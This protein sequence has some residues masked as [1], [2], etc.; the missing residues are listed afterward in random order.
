MDSSLG[1][2]ASDLAGDR[3]RGAA[4]LLA[5]EREPVRLSGTHAFLTGVNRLTAARWLAATG[6]TAT[7]TR[8]LTWHEAVGDKRP[9]TVHA[10][11]IL[12]PFAYLA[13]ARLLAG[14]GQ[15]AA[16][17]ENYI[18]FLANYDAPVQAHQGL[19]DEANAAVTRLGPR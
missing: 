2:F 5:L 13:R 17:R 16:A 14:Q 9:Q 8:L 11:V 6:D 12:A 18:R 7:A 3:T 10:N 4:V 1:A 19:A 15:R